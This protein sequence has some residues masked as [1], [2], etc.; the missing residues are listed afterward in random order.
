MK[1]FSHN[2]NQKSFL[3]RIWALQEPVGH[4]KRE[5]ERSG[6]N[7]SVAGI[8]SARGISSSNLPAYLDPKIRDEL[9]DPSRFKDMDT[10][11]KHIADQMQAGNSI[12][13]WSDYD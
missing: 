5:L 8:L 12:S 10:G 11:V 13:I 7:S 9:P 2:P 4:I 6:M 3:G 1:D